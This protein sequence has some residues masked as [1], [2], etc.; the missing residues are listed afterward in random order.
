MYQLHICNEN[1]QN[2]MEERER[3][4]YKSLYRKQ[5]EKYERKDERKRERDVSVICND[6]CERKRERERERERETCMYQLYYVCNENDR[7]SMKER[8][9]E[10]DKIRLIFFIL[11]AGYRINKTSLKPP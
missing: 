8:M 9:R 5:S 11:S 3:C 1:D 10:G 2:N 7:K 4:M 6:R